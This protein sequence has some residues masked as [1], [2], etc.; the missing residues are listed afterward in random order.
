MNLIKFI[1]NPDEKITF[2]GKDE[3]L[4]ESL[5]YYG[6]LITFEGK[7]LKLVLYE[8][9]IFEGIEVFICLLKK[10]INN[11]AGLPSSID[12]DLGYL[13]NQKMHADSDNKEKYELPGP[14]WCS[15]GHE[16]GICESWLYNNDQG[17]II[18]EI[19]PSYRW[20]FFDPEEGENYITYEEFM[21][22]YKPILFR[23]IPKEVAQQWLM[24]AEQLYAKIQENEAKELRRERRNQGPRDG[25]K[26]L[27]NS[28]SIYG[29]SN[30]IAAE[31]DIFIILKKDG[32]MRYHGHPRPW[33]DLNDDMQA[34]LRTNNITNHKGK[35]L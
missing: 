34:A 14:L 17:D 4:Q 9:F 21:Q 8:N 28:V 12:Q 22:N 23:T 32:E 2:V 13:W 7:N 6:M 20:H 30:R 25:Q 5:T 33:T 1:L 18:L 3:P 35:I 16:E 11:K 27:D 26:A 24:Q 19:T 29:S 15:T 10:V 31:D